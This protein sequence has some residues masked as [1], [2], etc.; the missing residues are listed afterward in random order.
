MSL[1]PHVTP[2]EVRANIVEE[3]Y[4]QPAG[5]PLVLCVLTLRNGFLVTGTA[6]CASFA[7]FDPDLGRRTARQYAFDQVWELMGYERRQ[8]LFE[9]A[10]EAPWDH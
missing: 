8:R 10:R 7:A 5:L 1:A 9:E 3:F 2:E 4:V 6:A